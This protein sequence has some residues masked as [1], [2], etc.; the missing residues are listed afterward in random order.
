MSH[1][2]HLAVQCALHLGRQLQKPDVVRNRR[3]FL[4]DPFG[5]PLLGQSALVDEPLQRQRHFDRPQIL[6]LDVL[7]QSHLQQ[8]LVIG[9]LPHISRNG[10]QSG[11]L[12]RP[13]PPFA[14]DNHILGPSFCCLFRSLLEVEP[15]DG[16]RLD[17]AQPGNGLRQLSERLFVEKG[18][19]L[20]R[21]GHDTRNLQFSDAVVPP[22]SSG[23]FRYVELFDLE[24][25]A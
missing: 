18:P 11:Q 6:P 12:R 3:P 8:C 1:R 22:R 5:E 15:F 16:D 17:H 21:I 13:I 2:D 20:V 10:R 4:P 25:G 14:A 24:D 9:R 23:L 19:R 7:D